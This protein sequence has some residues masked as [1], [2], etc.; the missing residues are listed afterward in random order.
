MKRI[1]GLLI[2]LVLF[3][4]SYGF[5]QNR[6]S[7]LDLRCETTVNPIGIV[8]RFPRFSWLVNASERDSKQLAYRI[9]VA[10]SMDQLTKDI[11]NCWDTKMTKSDSTIMVTY[12]GTALHAEKKYFWKVKI[13][14]Q[15]GHESPWSETASFK[16]GSVVRK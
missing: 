7:V 9:L 1:K 3:T 5:A 8:E 13:M 10:D 16:M 12:K 2:V 15:A 11:G 4:G 6:V 14:D